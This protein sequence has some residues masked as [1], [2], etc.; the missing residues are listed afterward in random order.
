MT[1]TEKKIIME[2]EENKDHFLKYFMLFPYSH[3]T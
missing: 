1:S 3:P 2:Q